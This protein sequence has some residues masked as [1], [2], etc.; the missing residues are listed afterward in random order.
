MEKKTHQSSEELTGQ[1]TTKTNE[2]KDMPVKTAAT[3]TEKN[4]VADEG[5]NRANLKNNEMPAGD[6]LPGDE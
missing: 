5:L 6:T 3:D 4:T 2:Q 1:E